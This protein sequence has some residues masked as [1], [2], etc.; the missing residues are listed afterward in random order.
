MSQGSIL[1][2]D[3]SGA[4]RE[5]LCELLSAEGYEVEGCAG[6][7][8]ALQFLQERAYDLVLTDLSMPEVDGMAVL[9]YLVNHFPETG[10]IIITGYGT[11]Q[12]A[13]D[14]MRLGAYDY[15][16]KPVEPRE[17]LVVIDRALEHQ[18]LRREN[19]TP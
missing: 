5:N 1:V 17:I 13:V 2:V 6:G 9:T 8:K 15:L 19:Y 16:C 10:C 14:A 3:D 7:K 12:T 11:I 4:V 18:R